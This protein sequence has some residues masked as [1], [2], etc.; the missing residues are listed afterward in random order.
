MKLIGSLLIPLSIGLITVVL[1]IQQRTLSQRNRQADLDISEKHRA[2]ELWLASAQKHNTILNYY[3]QE[4]I[5]LKKIK[6]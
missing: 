3:K 5:K 1:S 6:I 4:V 2:Q